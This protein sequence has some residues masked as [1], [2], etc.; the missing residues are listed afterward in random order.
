MDEYQDSKRR[1]FI[2]KVFNKIRIPLML[3]PALFVVIGLFGGG[4]L[5]AII[6]G[7]GWIPALGLEDFTFDHYIA[8]FSHPDFFPALLFSLKIST[9]SV[10]ML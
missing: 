2:R 10:I 7:F 6:S 3:T 1:V 9:I 5:N 8:A 4:L